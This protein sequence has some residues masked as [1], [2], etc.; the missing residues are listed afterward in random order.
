VCGCGDS[1]P[2][3]AP[4]E[5]VTV[6]ELTA[7]PSRDLD[8]LL[9]L[10]DTVGLIAR[11]RA[12]AVGLPAVFDHLQAGL[13]GPLNLHVGVI[14]TD[15]GTRAA[16][17]PTPG[18]AIGQIGQG[19]C[20][21][22]GKAGVLQTFAAQLT[23]RFLIDVEQAG[24]GRARNYTDPLVD[25][26]VRM[27]S[28]G[29]GGCRFGQPLAAMRAALDMN[30]T[31]AGFLRPDAALGVIFLGDVDDCSATTT[32]VF[33]SASPGLGELSSFRCTRFG[34][35][36]AEGGGTP[37]AMSE[38]GAKAGCGANASSTL[39]EGIEGYSDFL[40]G[41][42]PDPR[43]VVVAGIVAPPE[44][45]AVELRPTSSGGSAPALT[46][47]CSYP[48]I[49]GGSSA[50]NPAPRMRDFLGSFVD[51]SVHRS[52]C[53]ADPADGTLRIA[54]LLR[55]AMGSPCVDGQLAD[56][57]PVAPDL[58]VD[59]VV[60][61]LTVPTGRTIAPCAADAAARPCWRLEAD[62]AVC[63]SAQHLK[64]VVE[65][66]EAPDP[67]LVTRMSCVIER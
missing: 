57:D 10:G 32:Q 54:E 13:G 67:K 55:R 53:E 6:V 21:G 24:G 62:A 11:Q 47:V 43:R 4:P 51:R 64:L 35:T 12:L 38:P 33:S 56:M 52:I 27:T 7:T 34:V 28:A 9:V 50:A 61:E 49:G 15:M 20:A 40:R 2:E 65:R 19:G 22:S 31:N 41:M 42:K 46:H 63:T 66:D 45:L 5:R 60:D 29:A 30:P 1:P 37:D 36:C 26:L 25:T 48:E 17:S 58:Q 16:A 14:T 8:L 18:P 59:C 44:P 39:I 3:P 23:G